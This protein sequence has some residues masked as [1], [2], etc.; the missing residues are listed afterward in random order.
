MKNLKLFASLSLFLCVVAPTLG[1]TEVSAS[2]SGTA[3]N[4]PIEHFIVVMQENHTFDNY[5]GTYPG[6]E[7]IPEN[8]CMPVDPF[9]AK[10]TEC[11]KPFH[12]GDTEV[13]LEDP[14]HSTLTHRLQ[15]NE[16]KMDAF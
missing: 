11:V 4:T 8:V 2:Q 16:G 6:A 12:I 1:V 10:N 14:D 5:F 7:G 13:E 3:P 15:Y 9:D